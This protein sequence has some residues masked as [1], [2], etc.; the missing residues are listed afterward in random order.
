MN[1]TRITD[2][3]PALDSVDALCKKYQ[4]KGDKW[5]SQSA[6]E[7]LQHAQN[8]LDSLFSSVR[9]IPTRPFNFED[10]QSLAFRSLAGLF[11]ALQAQENPETFA[12]EI[13]EGRKENV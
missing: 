2:F 5:R 10:F 3:W 11:Q 9:E 8:H 4:D 1:R 7:Q 13:L 6:L 12:T